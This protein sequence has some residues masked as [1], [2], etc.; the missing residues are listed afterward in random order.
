MPVPGLRRNVSASGQAKHPDDRPQVGVG[1]N[2]P[3]DH[4]Q[5][6]ECGVWNTISMKQDLFGIY[7]DS[8][9]FLLNVSPEIFK[10]RSTTSHS[11]L[12]TWMWPWHHL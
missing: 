3:G 7:L 5:R 8:G 11:F 9:K 6:N 12:G 4:L 2:V 10:I 1:I